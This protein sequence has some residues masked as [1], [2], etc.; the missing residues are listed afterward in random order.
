MKMTCIIVTIYLLSIE[1]AV[2]LINTKYF[3]TYDNIE[4]SMIRRNAYA[5]SLEWQYDANQ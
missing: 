4:T 3:K 2:S 5:S 1:N